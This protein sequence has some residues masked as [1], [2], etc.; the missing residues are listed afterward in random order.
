[1][2]QPPERSDRENRPSDSTGH[3]KAR[4][5]VGQRASARGSSPTLPFSTAGFAG[6]RAQGKEGGPIDPFSLGPEAP[7]LPRILSGRALEAEGANMRP[8]SPPPHTT[9]REP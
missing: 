6:F 9:P 8:F 2:C 3:R 5:A 4:P 1:M 7:A